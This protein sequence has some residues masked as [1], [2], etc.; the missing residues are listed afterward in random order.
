MNDISSATLREEYARVTD[1]MEQFI[2]ECESSVGTLTPE[3]RNKVEKLLQENIPLLAGRII[4]L[5]DSDTPEEDMIVYMSEVLRIFY[6]SVA[7]IDPKMEQMKIF[8][9]M[10]LRINESFDT[11]MNQSRVLGSKTPEV[12]VKMIK[13]AVKRASK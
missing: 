11:I 12:R 13:E 1:S 5:E 8:R 6:W 7:I 3:V 10:Y 4:H 2:E 9:K